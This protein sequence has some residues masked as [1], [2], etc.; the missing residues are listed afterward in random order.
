[1]RTRW[2]RICDSYTSLMDNVSDETF[3]CYGE[4]REDS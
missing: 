1:M 3:C 2:K 4:W